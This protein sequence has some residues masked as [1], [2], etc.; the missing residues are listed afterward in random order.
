MIVAPLGA[1]TLDSN[2]ARRDRRHRIATDVSGTSC[3]D[4]VDLLQNIERDLLFGIDQRNHFEL[5]RDLLELN[6]RFDRSYA[7]G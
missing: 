1:L 3:N 6:T 4:A 5:Q 2:V 7:I